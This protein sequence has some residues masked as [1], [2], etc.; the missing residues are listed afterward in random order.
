MEAKGFICSL[1]KIKSKKKHS[2]SAF[3]LA[4][5][6]QPFL[7]AILYQSVRLSEPTCTTNLP[8]FSP[9]NKPMKASA[10]FSMP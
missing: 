6:N 7:L 9:F 4:I 8:K 3:R 5:Y 1:F 10:E 2:M